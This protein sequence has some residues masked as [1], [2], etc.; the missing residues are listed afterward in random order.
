[1][2]ASRAEEVLRASKVGREREAHL[3]SSAS[4]PLERRAAVCIGPDERS[5]EK[6][7]GEERSGEVNLGGGQASQ[8][9][10]AS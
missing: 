3:S 7:R 10:I 5:G 8:V 6:R 9:S 1:M 4:W 2:A